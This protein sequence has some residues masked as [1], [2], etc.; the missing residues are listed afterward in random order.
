MKTVFGGNQKYPCGNSIQICHKPPI[1]EPNHTRNKKIQ[2]LR[3]LKIEI[4]L[5]TP[6]L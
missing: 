5:M 3:I 4:P 2:I 6:F 1:K